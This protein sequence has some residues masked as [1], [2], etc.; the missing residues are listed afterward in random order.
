M[1]AITLLIRGGVSALTLRMAQTYYELAFG[2]EFGTRRWRLGF[3][4]PPNL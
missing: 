4:H 1:Y 3:R 2:P